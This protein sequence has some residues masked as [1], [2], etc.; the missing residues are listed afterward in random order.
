MG[1]YSVKAFNAKTGRKV[2][3]EPCIRKLT[4]QMLH[5]LGVEL[6][7]K[8]AV[9]TFVDLDNEGLVTRYRDGNLLFNKKQL[10]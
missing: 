7:K 9:V 4:T 3:I 6:S 8:D 5:D 10:F 2:T 1:T